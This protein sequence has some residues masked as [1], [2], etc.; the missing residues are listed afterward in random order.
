MTHYQSFL[1]FQLRLVAL[2][3]PMAGDLG[4]VAGADY[5]CYEQSFKARGRG[6]YRAF[7]SDKMQSVKHLVAKKFANLPVVN[8]KVCE[9]H[10]IL[11][12]IIFKI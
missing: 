2:N 5:Q 7:L 9:L 8:S 3:E 4:G 1:P 6:V 10:F 11:P 12:E